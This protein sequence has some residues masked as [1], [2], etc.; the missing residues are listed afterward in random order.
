MLTDAEVDVYTRAFAA[1]GFRGP[2]NWYRN[3]DR[4]QRMFPDIGVRPLE[5]PCLMVTAEWDAALPPDL[6]SGMPAL[7]SDLEIHMIPQCG[8][9][10]QQDKPAELTALLTDWLSRRFVK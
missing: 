4:N 7:C 3:V 9:W 10:T 5:M 1:R 6:A 8:H 2:I